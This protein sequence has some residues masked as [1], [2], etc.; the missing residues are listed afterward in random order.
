MLFWKSEASYISSFW[1]V[2]IF[3]WGV[4]VMKFLYRTTIGQLFAWI[5]MSSSLSD[6]CSF[7][8]CLPLLEFHFSPIV[9]LAPSEAAH[10][11]PP[12]SVLAGIT[13]CVTVQWADQWA[14]PAKSQKRKCFQ[15]D[16]LS[17]PNTWIDAIKFLAWA[18]G[19]TAW[20]RREHRVYI[21]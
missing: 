14:N 8:Q 2:L 19:E 17:T 20:A 5:G 9:T 10:S 7:S 15:W 13:V 4:Y 3:L 1:N 21:C 16:Q 18:Q 11:S 12:P 6:E